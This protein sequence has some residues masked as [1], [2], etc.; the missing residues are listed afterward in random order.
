MRVRK[1][2]KEDK[3]DAYLISSFC[4]H[5]RIEDVEKEREKVESEIFDDWGA[6][7]DDG[8]LAARIINNKYDFYIDGK[9]VKTGGIGAVSTLPE[10]R[11][12]G[13]VR[14]IFKELLNE[15]YKNGEVISTLYPFNH[16]FYRKQGYDTVTFQN[17]Y[18]LA[19]ALLENYRT[20]CKVTMWHKGE[21]V[22]KYLKIYNEFAKNF[23]FSVPRDEKM[24]LEHINVEAQY[25]ERKF[26]YLF[27]KEDTDLAYVTFTDIKNEPGAILKVEEAAWSNR[28][29]FEAVLAFLGRFD[30]DYMK[31]ELP[32]PYGLDLLRIIRT[33]KAYDIKKSTSQAFMVRVIN[34]LELLKVLKKPAGCSFTIKITDDIILE[35]NGLY[36]VTDVDVVKVS[37]DIV[38]DLDVSERTFAQLAT[39]CINLDE[40]LLKP[41]AVV[42]DNEDTLRS[43]FCEKKIFINEHF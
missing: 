11:D 10:Y 28:E 29:G 32:L 33:R 40:A 34:A 2:V 41:D 16:S 1:L 38:P 17:V 14:A 9:T 39:G 20:V 23:N 7:T 19:P 35:N 15:A 18:E 5:A 30:A 27:T 43:V 22:D 31:I 36:K 8:V 42:N 37:E 26:T 6:F 3:F 13:A 12:T 24:M 4:F 25:M 21:P